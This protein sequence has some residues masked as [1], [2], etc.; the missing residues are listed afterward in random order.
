VGLDKDA[1]SDPNLNAVHAGASMRKA[2]HPQPKASDVADA[3]VGCLPFPDS[4]STFEYSPSRAK[5]PLLLVI[6]S[7]WSEGDHMLDKW[8]RASEGEPE[9]EPLLSTWIRS[10][11][12]PAME[13]VTA[14]EYT[15]GWQVTAA[16]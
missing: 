1:S 5:S 16:V 3:E 6:M 11:T 10:N 7:T 2:Q 9:G 12:Q 15:G 4:L 13:L 8:N 14:S